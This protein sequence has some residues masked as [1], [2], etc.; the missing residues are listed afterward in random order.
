MTGV[1]KEKV[2]PML[3]KNSKTEYFCGAWPSCV[4]FI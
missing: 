1:G 4:Y 2:P 3:P